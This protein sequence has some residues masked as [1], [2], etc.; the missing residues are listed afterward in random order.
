MYILDVRRF[1]Y[2]C[3]LMISC[4]DNGSYFFKNPELDVDWM[5][6]VQF[7]KRFYQDYFDLFDKNGEGTIEI[8]EMQQTYAKYY[9]EI[10]MPGAGSIKGFK[11]DPEVRF[12]KC[13]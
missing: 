11:L 12:N 13:N 1:V 6:F 4:T 7:P 2:Q 3:I 8:S 10:H 5:D 9:D